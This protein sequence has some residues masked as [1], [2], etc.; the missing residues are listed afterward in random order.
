[1]LARQVLYHWN[2]DASLSYIIYCSVAHFSSLKN[3]YEVL[4]QHFFT[5]WDVLSDV[6]GTVIGAGEFH[7]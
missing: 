6:S 5:L 1:V 3:H 4:I 2:H 7:G